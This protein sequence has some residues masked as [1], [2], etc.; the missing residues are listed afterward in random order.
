VRHTEI[1]IV[2]GGMAGSTAAAMLAKAG[3]DAVLIDPHVTYPADFRCE[4]LD[5][6]Q[7]A[8]LKKTGVG[9]GVVAAATTSDELWVARYGRVVE[10]R[11]NHQVDTLYET[12]VNAMRVGVRGR[13]RLVVGKC[14]GLATSADRQIV[15]LAGG[16]E[17]SARLVILANGLNSAL[18]R[19]MGLERKDISLGHSIGI[20][21]DIGPVG[22][23]RFDFRALTYYPEHVAERIAYLSMFPLGNG[24]RANLFA[25][26]DMRDPWLKALRDAPVETLKRALPGLARL[27]GE[28]S[29]TSFVQVRP[30]DLYV[31]TGTDR[32]GVVLVGDAYGTSCPAAGTGLNKVLTDVERLV[33]HHIPTWLATPGMGA[34]KIGAFYRDP[35]KVAADAW[36]AERALYVRAI[37]TDRSIAWRAR[38]RVRYVGQAGVGLIRAARMRLAGGPAAAGNAMGTSGP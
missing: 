15:T 5:E 14:L 10:R 26:R 4:K 25:Y 28:F 13:V 31:T 33:N 27:T 37:S 38:R 34:D 2:G 11:P 12:M 36:A 21:F 20:G 19:N 22:R 3:I 7:L 1:A 24:T 23:S 16:E 30:V 8:L 32:A 17:I 9:D 35:V 18:R 29:V 6:S